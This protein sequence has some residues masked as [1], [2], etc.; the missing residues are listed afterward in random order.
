MTAWHGSQ[1]LKDRIVA[2][3]HQHRLADAIV[4]GSYQIRDRE[5][6]LGYRGCAVGCLLDKQ[7]GLEPAAGWHG[8][9][10]KQ[11]GIPA[12]VAEA[13]D[14]TFE[15]FGIGDDSHS[16]ASDFAVAVVEA[17]PV[18]A[19]LGNLIERFDEWSENYARTEFED[20][21]EEW[22]AEEDAQAAKLIELLRNA[23]VVGSDAAH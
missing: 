15:N 17:I 9:V 3:M 1:E 2:R 7:P 5:L 13:I 18:G 8:E 16:R 10:E 22:R 19:D 6:P 4:Q 11:F 14:S 20:A 12:A 23:P 21:E